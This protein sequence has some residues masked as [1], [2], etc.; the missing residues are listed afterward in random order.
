MIKCNFML[1]IKMTC[2]REETKSYVFKI[3]NENIAALNLLRERNLSSIMIVY[4]LR[5]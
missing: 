5:N 3:S 1:L 2:H 4:G